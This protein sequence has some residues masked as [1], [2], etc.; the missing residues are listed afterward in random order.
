[1]VWGM[2]FAK[3]TVTVKKMIGRQ[4]SAK[5]KDMLSFF[6]VPAMEL[7]YEKDYIFQQDN[8]LIHV[9]REMKKYFTENKISLLN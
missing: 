5:Y 6:A 2:V 3:G 7:E 9:S 1:M 8:C 4:N